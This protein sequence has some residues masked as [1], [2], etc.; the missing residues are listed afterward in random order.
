MF[1][2]K[3]P[4]DQIIEDLRKDNESLR[5]KLMSMVDA[6]AAAL[7]ASFNRV[8]EPKPI[9]EPK[10]LTITGLDERPIYTD[11]AQLEAAFSK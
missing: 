4:R 5:L 7:S 1:G 11:P 10:T 8:R 9:T 2:T 6:R 3:D